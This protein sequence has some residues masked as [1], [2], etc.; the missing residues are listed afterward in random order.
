MFDFLHTKIFRMAPHADLTSASRNGAPTPLVKET[1]QNS[2]PKA[3]RPVNPE[4]APIRGQ[5][6]A[7][8]EDN[9]TAKLIKTGLNGLV[10]N[11]SRPTTK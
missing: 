1:A 9:I 3:S 10:G 11:V 5:V 2:D 7:L 6:S 4:T 8:F